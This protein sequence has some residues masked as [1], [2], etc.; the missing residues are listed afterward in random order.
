QANRRR[1]RPL[2]SSFRGD[3]GG[4]GSAARGGIR[5]APKARKE[6]A[7]AAAQELLKVDAA[8][9]R[10]VAAAQSR[11]DATAPMQQAQGRARGSLVPEQRSSGVATPPRSF[12]DSGCFFN[13]SAGQPWNS[14]LSDTVTWYSISIFL[15]IYGAVK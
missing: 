8:R 9:V 10:K 12:T 7:A 6:A 2:Y 3:D 15:K 11:K 14:Q 4:A 13:G 5:F 1:R